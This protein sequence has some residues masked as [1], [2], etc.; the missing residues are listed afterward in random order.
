MY[1]RTYNPP[2]PKHNEDFIQE[3]SDLLIEFVPEYDDIRICGYF[4]IHVFCPSSHLASEF[5][6]LLNT[7]DLLQSLD[8]P[9]H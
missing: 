8:E 7:I 3:F 4:N 5:L 1:K 9:T 2:P 6:S